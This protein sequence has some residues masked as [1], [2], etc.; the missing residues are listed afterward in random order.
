[1]S[2]SSNI[3]TKE[4][5][6]PEALIGPPL[7]PSKTV[8]FLLGELKSGRFQK[9]QDA[10]LG[11]LSVFQRFDL[12]DGSFAI[13]VSIDF[14]LNRSNQWSVIRGSYEVMERLKLSNA[15]PRF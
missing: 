15:P 2:D 4:I 10:P 3:P 6:F 13:L 1:M 9:T 12:P 11:D 8:N 14:Y 5:P 7:D